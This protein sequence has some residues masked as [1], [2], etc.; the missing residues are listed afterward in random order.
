[1]QIKK[2][3]DFG[4]P[5]FRENVRI[6]KRSAVGVRNELRADVTWSML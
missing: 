3:R 2:R 5:R 1:M 6:S 4:V